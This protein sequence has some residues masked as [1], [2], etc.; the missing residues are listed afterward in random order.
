MRWMPISNLKDSSTNGK[1]MRM[2]VHHKFACGCDAVTD[3]D[4]KDIALGAVFECPRC[5]QVW[6]HVYPR[7][8]GRAWVKISDQDV[9]FHDLLGRNHEYETED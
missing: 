8:G 7:R 3:C 4:P 5:R 6:G 9:S 2:H 1:E